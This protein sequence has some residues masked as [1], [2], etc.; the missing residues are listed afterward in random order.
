VNRLGQPSLRWDLL[1]TAELRPHCSGRTVV[2]GHTAQR[3][4]EILD[5]GFLVG[6]DTDCLRGGWLTALDVASGEVVQAN[7]RG[8]VRRRRRPA[9]AADP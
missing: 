5:L 9:L 2:V 4:G 7:Q 3:T 1:E 6:I 8:E